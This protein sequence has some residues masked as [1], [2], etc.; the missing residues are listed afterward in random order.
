MCLQTKVGKPYFSQHKL[1]VKNLKTNT[2]LSKH[3]V[4]NFDYGKTK[5]LEKGDKYK[6]KL[7]LEMFHIKENEKSI[8]NRT[9]IENLS[10][11]YFEL[12]NKSLCN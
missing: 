11:L 6:Y 1:S 5:I 2:A 10:N 9:D 8:N 4:E 12:I 7:F 3:C